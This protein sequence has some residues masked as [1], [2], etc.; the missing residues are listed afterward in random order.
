MW[1]FPGSKRESEL[2][3]VYEV[4]GFTFKTANKQPQRIVQSGPPD[5]QNKLLLQPG[6]LEIDLP[7]VS[8][9]VCLNIAGNVQ[10]VALSPDEQVLFETTVESPEAAQT[11]EIDEGCIA[12]LRLTSDGESLLST[13]CAQVDQ[14]SITKEPPKKEPPK[15]PARG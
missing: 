6:A 8:D 14:C 3:P 7:F 1:I 12:K 9:S 11:V 13:L 10:V 2:P 5:G 15:T 4:T